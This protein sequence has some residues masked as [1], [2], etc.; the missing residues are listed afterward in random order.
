MLNHVSDTSVW[1]AYYRALETDRN[2]SIFKDQFA[3]ILLRN[4]SLEFAKEKPNV[5]KWTNWT[6][7]M[8]TFIIDNMIK[9]LISQGHTT[10]VNLGAGLDTRPYRMQIDAKIKW[11]EVDYPHLVEEKNNVLLPFSPSCDLERIGLDLSQ[12]DERI[13]CHFN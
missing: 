11:I 9:D 8:R 1:V 13:S 3:K 2:D 4:R 12:H 5:N 6:V 10:F 7:V